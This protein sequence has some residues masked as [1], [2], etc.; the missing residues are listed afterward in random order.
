VALKSISTIGGLKMNQAMT[1]VRVLKF[2]KFGA[3]S[4]KNDHKIHNFA[5]GSRKLA[6]TESHRRKTM[7]LAF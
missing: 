2:S 6:F 3:F 4:L 1:K 7:V 5:R